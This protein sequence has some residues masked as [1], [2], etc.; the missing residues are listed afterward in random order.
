MRMVAAAR[1]FGEANHS[2]ANDVGKGTLFYFD[3]VF[4]VTSKITNNSF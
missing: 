1:V 3:E 2:A 4:D